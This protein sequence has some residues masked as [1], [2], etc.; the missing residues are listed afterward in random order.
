MAQR[1]KV[2]GPGYEEVA[3]LLYQA[4]EKLSLAPRNH[5]EPAAIGKL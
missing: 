1:M 3:A 4:G 5:L 2:A